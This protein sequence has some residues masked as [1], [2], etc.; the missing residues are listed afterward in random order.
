MT[1][2]IRGRQDHRLSEHREDLTGE[3]KILYISIQTKVLGKGNRT[4]Y[5][6]LDGLWIEV[7]STLLLSVSRRV[8]QT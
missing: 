3:H 4:F 1:Q 7:A 5:N 2:F 6:T 8:A